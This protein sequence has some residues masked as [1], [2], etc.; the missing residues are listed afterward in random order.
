MLDDMELIETYDEIRRE[1]ACSSNICRKNVRSRYKNKK[2]QQNQEGILCK[3]NL[4]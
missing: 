1:Q 2:T 4:C 3:L